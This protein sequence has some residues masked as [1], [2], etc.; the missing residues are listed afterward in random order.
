MALADTKETLRI[1][2]NGRI[3]NVRE[4]YYDQY[5]INMAKKF[6]IER[7]RAKEPELFMKSAR[8]IGEVIGHLDQY[9]GDEFF[10]YR[11]RKLIDKDVF[12]MEGNLKAMRF[13]SVRLAKGCRGHS[14]E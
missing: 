7:E 9:L 12:E 1:W 14:S 4:D 5:M 13:N 8:L 10:Q 6:Q 3:Q 11:L 2:K